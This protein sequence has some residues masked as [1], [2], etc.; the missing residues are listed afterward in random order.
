MACALA[1]GVLGW[2]TTRLTQQPLLTKTVTGFAM[3]L[4]GDLVAQASERPGQPVDVRRLAA[5]TAFGAAWT[6]PVNHRWLPIVA[7]LPN[8]GSKLLVQHGLLNPLVYVPV[9]LTWNAMAQGKDW[10]ETRG[11]VQERYPKVLSSV[12]AFWVPV[13]ALIFA[14]VPESLQSVSMAAISLVWN[15]AFSF[16]SNSP[17]LP[18]LQRAA[19]NRLGDLR[20][21]SQGLM[22][23]SKPVASAASAAPTSLQS[24]AEPTTTQRPPSSSP[25]VKA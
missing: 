15:V 13:T 1:R 3:A 4:A 24:A 9:F 11:Y 23:A 25:Q 17:Q 2:Y 21:M 7:R 12:L 14:R 18:A 5:F 10:G 8:L 19:S 16:V 22:A 20:R 6:G